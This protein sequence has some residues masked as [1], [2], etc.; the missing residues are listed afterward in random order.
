MHAFVGFHDETLR[1][2]QNRSNFIESL[3]FRGLLVHPMTYPLLFGNI[4]VVRVLQERRAVLAKVRLHPF[5]GLPDVQRT[6]MY[7]F[8]P[9]FSI[10]L[11]PI[12]LNISFLL[13]PL[14]LL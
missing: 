2:F 5:S 3:N 14:S 1:K 11:P 7:T 12:G 6:I 9:F 10:S 8:H 4:C 13:L